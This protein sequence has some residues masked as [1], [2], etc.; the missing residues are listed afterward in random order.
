MQNGK[1]SKN[2]ILRNSDFITIILDLAV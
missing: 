1:V 2:M